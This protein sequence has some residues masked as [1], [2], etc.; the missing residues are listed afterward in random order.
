MEK[1]PPPDRLWWGRKTDV[2]PEREVAEGALRDRVLRMEQFRIEKVPLGGSGIRGWA[3]TGQH[4]K[5]RHCW[6]SR[7]SSTTAAE[8]VW[9]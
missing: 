7:S 3:V 6:P 2:S 8:R 9:L 1:V 5:P 4:P